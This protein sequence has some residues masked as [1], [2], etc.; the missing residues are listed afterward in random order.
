VAQV[1]NEPASDA[2]P[3]LDY[4]HARDELSRVVDALESGGLTLAE[5]LAL[6]ERGEELAKAC[7]RLLAGARERLAAAIAERERGDEPAR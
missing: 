1:T 5:S 6:W 2:K 3:E 7:E 4:E